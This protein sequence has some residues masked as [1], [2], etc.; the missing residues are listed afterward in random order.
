MYTLNL[1]IA[2]VFLGA[3]ILTGILHAADW[4]QFR[5]PGGS[6]VSEEQNLP[7]KWSAAEGLLWKT[8]LQGRGLS[9]PVIA[10]GRLFLPPVLTTKNPAFM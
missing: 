1:T 4:P 9:S 7:L 2:R 10:G 3:F 8:P 6:A 5:G